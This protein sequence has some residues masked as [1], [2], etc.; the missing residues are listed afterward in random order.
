VSELPQSVSAPPQATTQAAPTDRWPAVVSC[1]ALGTAGYAVYLG[2]PVILG[3]LADSIGLDARQIGWLASVELGGMLVASLLTSRLVRSGRYRRI[4]VAGMALAVT[5]NLVST[6]VTAFATLGALRFA[7]GVGSGLCYSTAIAALSLSREPAR[8]FSLFGISLIIIGSLELYVLPMIAAQWGAGG[9]FALLGTAYL[10]PAA[11]LKFLPTSVSSGEL[12]ALSPNGGTSR[13]SVF[14]RLAVFCLAAIVCF[15]IAT[16][17]FWAYSERIGVAIG[18][19][20]Q[21]V[22]NA[23]TVL[24]LLSL[25]GCALA[26]WAARRWGQHR[27]QLVALSVIL[28]VFLGWSRHLESTLYLAGIALFFEAWAVSAVLQMSTLSVF[29]VTGRYAALIPAAQGIGQSAGPFVAGSLL[30]WHESYAQLLAF[31]GALVAAALA[32]YAWVYRRLRRDF[33]ALADS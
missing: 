23:L 6:T 11:L 20:Q 3:T 7:A 29:D 21:T 12:A 19:A 1:I 8:N 17:A 30:G 26:W 33:P 5:T 15:N 18:M 22:A 32:F 2:L 4:A 16:S 14:A 13:A 27:T 25:G 28:L 9:V 31:E 24:N 10:A